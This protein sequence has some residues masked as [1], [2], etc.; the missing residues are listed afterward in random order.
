MNHRYANSVLTALGFT[1]VLVVLIKP[2]CV[3]YLSIP[4]VDAFYYY[5]MVAVATATFCLYFRHVRIDVIGALMFLLCG[6][7]LATTIYHH[8]DMNLWWRR[9]FTFLVAVLLTSYGCRKHARVFIAALFA[10]SFTFSLINI[11]VMIA[12]PDGLYASSYSPQQANYFLG[13]RNN[14]YQVMIIAIGTG[15][16]LGALCGKKWRCLGIAAIGAGIAQLA[17]ANSATS[18]VALA[19]MSVFTLVILCGKM[20]PLCN[21]FT[22][23]AGYAAFYIGIVVLRMQD[24]FAPLIVDVLHK[25]ITFTGRT[26]IWDVVFQ[27]I[28]GMKWIS[29]YGTSGYRELSVNG[30]SYAHAHNELLNTMLVGGIPA[31]LLLGVLVFYPGCRLVRRIKSEAAAFIALMIGCFVIVGCTEVVDCASFYM[32][33]AIGG[34]MPLS[35]LQ[36]S[37]CDTIRREDEM[38]QTVRSR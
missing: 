14:V 5:G 26:F 11:V 27:K 8:G 38:A 20:R 24:R 30:M 34:C 25:D 21:V 15:F 4:V 6:F 10:V 13:H 2:G 29:G 19:V 23:L 12:V 36:D 18:T 35:F 28:T 9:W 33:L 3:D 17:L 7:V 37:F 1:A 22:F 16:L 31:V 32:A